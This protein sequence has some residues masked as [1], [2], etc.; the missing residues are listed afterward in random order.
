MKR[1]IYFFLTISC[2]GLVSSCE[3][4]FLDVNVSPNNPTEVPPNLVFVAGQVRGAYELY[5]PLN[6]SGSLW[7]QQWASTGGQY[8]QQDQYSV[9]TNNFNNQWVA[10]YPGVLIDFQRVI[11]DGTTLEIPNYV[12]P[13]MIMKA[14]YFMIS[15]DIW[16]DVPFTEALRGVEE[17]TPV[18][19]PQENVYRGILTDLDA[20][21]AL[22]DD[23]PAALGFNGTED[24]M[25]GGDMDSW[26]R[27]ANTLKLKAFMR[28]TNADP[29]AAQQGVTDVLSSGVPL[30]ADQAQD[31]EVPFF[32]G[33]QNRNPQ[34][35]QNNAR[36]NDFGPST[37][38][39]NLMNGLNDPRIGMYFDEPVNFPGTQR[40]EVNGTN[41]ND[42]LPNVGDYSRLGTNFKAQTTPSQL[43]T[44]SERLFLEAEAAIRGW[45]NPGDAKS[46][47][48]QAVT[49]AFGKYEIELGT[50]L[51]DGEP[52]AFPATGT[53][54]EQLEALFT[55]K[56]LSLFSRGL[57]AFSEYRRTLV[58]ALTPAANN[59]N[60]N[61]I[62]TRFPY[63]QSEV[64][65]NSSNVPSATIQDKVW[66]AK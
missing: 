57:E 49:A 45:H 37:F 55:Q 30:I 11:D 54:D 26:R 46:L 56:Y 25:Y 8:R 36:P 15:T 28:M 44:N 31:A 48:D 17:L 63:A 62:P 21:I 4:D 38:M 33:V 41:A 60:D 16:G 22:I 5:G 51:D 53:M 42:L 3:S 10:L 9:A 7:T 32:T 58:P 43:L 34:W 52:A 66:F 19:D 23:D 65:N 14:Y 24:I 12:A 20:A 61:I 47:Y 2:V 64:S 6:L 59:T 27:F 1:L 40:G 29:A 50:Y 18:Y 13:A 39:L 35:E